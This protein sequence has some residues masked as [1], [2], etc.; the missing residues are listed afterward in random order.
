MVRIKGVPRFQVDAECAARVE[1]H[2]RMRAEKPSQRQR[3]PIFD[4]PYLE[5]AASK[6]RE[7]VPAYFERRETKKRPVAALLGG[8]R[9][10][11]SSIR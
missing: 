1:K 4:M 8:F 10:V 2:R 3:D 6:P 9:F 7:E 11:R 5:H